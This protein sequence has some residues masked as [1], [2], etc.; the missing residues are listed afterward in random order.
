MAL[1][2][3]PLQSLEGRPHLQLECAPLRLPLGSS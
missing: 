3:G 2:I 1:L